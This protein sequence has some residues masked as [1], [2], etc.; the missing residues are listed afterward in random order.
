MSV[1]KRKFKN[2]TRW[3][4]DIMYPDGKR[5]R[6]IVG[7]KKEADHVHR[8]IEAEIIQGK[9]NTQE[10]EGIQEIEDIT[11]R[12]LA[13]K[14]LEYS[15]ANKGRNTFRGDKCRIESH[16]LPYFKDMPIKLITPKMV[17][18]Y[19]QKRLKTGVT[20]CTVNHDITNLSHM[21]RMAM[22]WKYIDRNIVS[23]VDKMKVPEK[24]PHVPK[25]G[26]N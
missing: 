4:V 9:W 11:F 3:F 6:K 23:S 12:F 14:Y 25:S 16:L 20:P 10:T 2:A 18:D 17:D 19:K 7:T 22:R 13:E 15:E 8:Q 1:R 5:F 24:A 21:L 26:G